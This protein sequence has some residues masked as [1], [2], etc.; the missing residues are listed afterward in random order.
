MLRGENKPLGKNV[1]KQSRLF[2][3]QDFSKPPYA[4]GYCEA[5]QRDR[6]GVPQPLLAST[7]SL[8][9]LSAEIQAL[10]MPSSSEGERKA[11]FK[12]IIPQADERQYATYFSL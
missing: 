10:Q 1:L 7:E 11:R 6:L 2:Y 4:S 5:R 3:S 9:P 12:V 8:E